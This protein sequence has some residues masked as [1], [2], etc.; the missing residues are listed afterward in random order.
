V[1]PLE[2]QAL[3]DRPSDII[4]LTLALIRRHTEDKH[5]QPWL[6]VEAIDVLLGHDWPGNVREL[7]NVIQ[8]ALVLHSD[9]RICAQDIVID[10]PRQNRVTAEIKPAQAWMMG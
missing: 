10:R 4:P 8:R 2:T 3:A 5:T 1:F 9:A 7:E 6:S